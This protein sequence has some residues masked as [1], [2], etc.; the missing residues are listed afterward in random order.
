[1]GALHE[2]IFTF[3]IV[4]QGILLRMGNVSVKHVEKIK[5]CTLCSV[6]LWKNMIQPDMPLMTI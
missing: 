1:M 2:D 5:T 3:I 6:T 4:S